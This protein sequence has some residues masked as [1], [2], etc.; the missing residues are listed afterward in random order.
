MET[1][2][3][4]IISV[5]AALEARIAPITAPYEA[6][7]VAFLADKFPEAT[8]ATKT[9]LASI[10]SPYADQ[11]P[12]MNPAHVLF[13]VTAYLALIGGGR[14]IMSQVPFKL[15]VKTYALLNNVVLTSLSLFMAVEVLRQ[16]FLGRYSLFGNPLVTPEQG[17]TGMAK[18]VAVFYLSK[19]LEFND[20]IIMVLKKNFHQIS[21]LHVYH[22]AS[23]F[24]IWWLVT[25]WAPTGESY[26]SAFLNSG[27]HVIMYGYYFLS[28]LGFKQVT[29]IKKYIT[30]AQMTQFMLMMVQATYNL[31]DGFVLRPEKAKAPNAYPLE[32]SVLLWVYMVTML[33]LFG[34]F[35]RQSYKNKA[36]AT[37]GAAVPAAKKSS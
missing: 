8:T 20:T 5:F 13:L 9:F 23:I 3:D 37:K 21:F 24:M 26:F 35:Y 7:V 31:I 4:L 16:A 10:R 33:A 2:T 22:H 34:N 27:I 36:R 15:Q 14:L 1:T 30:S 32:L 17:G 18:I 6:H 29:F 11:L 19:I 25:L 12:F 28:A